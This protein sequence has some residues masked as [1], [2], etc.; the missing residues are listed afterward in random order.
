M[1]Q[2]KDAADA[3]DADGDRSPFARGE[4]FGVSSADEALAWM[5][6]GV[7]F[8]A[9]KCGDW[10]P[11]SGYDFSCDEIT[12][13]RRS[14]NCTYKSPFNQALQQE[15]VAL[16]FEPL[17]EF[18]ARGRLHRKPLEDA[19]PEVAMAGG[20]ASSS[21]ML[22]FHLITTAAMN[23]LAARIEL[24]NKRKGDKTWSAISNNQACLLDKHYVMERI[25]HIIKHCFILRDKINSGDVSS[26]EDDAAAIIWGGMFLCSAMEAMSIN[27]KDA[28][29]HGQ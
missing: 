28:A 20:L 4:T 3:A 22:P 14:P 13:F 5:R 11:A 7:S 1:D 15:Q 8:E 21:E 24:G 2:A 26:D 25:G 18:Q 27:K 29:E 19:P 16:D 23:R 6:E 17:R 12:E 10:L 9:L